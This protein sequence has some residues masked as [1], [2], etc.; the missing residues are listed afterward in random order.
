MN[1]QE[2]ILFSVTRDQTKK[3]IKEFGSF[4][5]PSE[6]LSSIKVLKVGIRIILFYFTCKCF[7]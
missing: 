5:G 7:S 2:V 6:F 1:Y 3:I 4:I